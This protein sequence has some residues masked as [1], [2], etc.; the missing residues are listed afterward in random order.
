M[1]L[2]LL[3]CPELKGSSRRLQRNYYYLIYLKCYIFTRS[4]G[5]LCFDD[6]DNKLNLLYLL[7]LDLKAENDVG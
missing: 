6:D 7:R 4:E 3:N 5:I 1:R 2:N